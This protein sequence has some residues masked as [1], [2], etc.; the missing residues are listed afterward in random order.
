MIFH[1]A[2]RGNLKDWR[3]IKLTLYHCW[4][5]FIFADRNGRESF[6]QKFNIFSF[7]TAIIV[8]YRKNPGFFCLIW[9]NIE[10]S[11]V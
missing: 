6:T 9:I 8:L 11:L 10:K 4:F 7:F 1:F 2:E 5:I 3:R